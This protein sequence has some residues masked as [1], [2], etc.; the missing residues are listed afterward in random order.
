MTIDS[1]KHWLEHGDLR[2]PLMLLRLADGGTANL[3]EAWRDFSIDEQRGTY[4][5]SAKRCEPVWPHRRSQE[6]QGDDE[7][8]ET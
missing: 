5:N 2:R 7:Y 3:A 1:F 8:S 6:R 4:W